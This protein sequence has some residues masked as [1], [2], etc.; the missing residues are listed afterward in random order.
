MHPWIRQLGKV[1]LACAI[2]A[3]TVVAVSG[4]GS[5]APP[6]PTKVAYTDLGLKK[7]LPPYL[8]DTILERT[9][10]ANTGPLAVS[11]YGLV[12]NLR[13]SGDTRAPT[14]V[15]DWMI[16]EMYRHGMGSLRI[17]GYRDMTPERVLADK[18]AAIVTVGAFIPPGA[19]KGQRVDAY[20]VALPQSDTASLAGGT[21]YQCELRLMGANPLNPAG[22]VNK[23]VEARGPLFINPA[24]ALQTPTVTDGVARSGAR[25]ATVLG[26]GYITADR[27]VQLRL[28]TP[29]WNISRAVE[30]V[31]NQRFQQVADKPRQDGRGMCA[32]EAQDE[33]YL[34]LYVPMSYKGNWEHF[35]GVVTHLYINLNPAVAVIKAQEL[36]QE[37]TQPGALLEDISYALEAIGPAAVPYITPL[38]AH[39]SPDVRFAMARAGTYLGDLASEDAL[40]QIAKTTG[41]PFRLNAIVCLGE[42]PNNVEINRALATCLDSEESLIRINAYK[43]LAAGGDMHVISRPVNETFIL[44][45]VDSK[46]PPLIYA[47]RIGEPRLAVFGNRTSLNQ[48]VTFTAFDTQL[49]IA[50]N[51]ERPHLLSIYYRGEELQEPIKTLSRPNVAELA[52]R[53][54]GSGDEKLRFSY[55][56]IV[57]M[58]QSMS[59]SGKVSSAFVLQDVPMVDENLL[60][61]PDATGGGGGG[62]PVGEPEAPGHRAE[63]GN[64]TT[65]PQAVGVNAGRPTGNGAPVG[66]PN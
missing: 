7:S 39:P 46:G 10:L 5:Q 42:V 9:D 3:G 11:S 65:P 58:L 59:D 43:V 4:C 8:K 2:A 47:N 15:R 54:G 51:P 66:R 56:D 49:T 27:P 34:N 17:P 16:K 41:H 26:G 53:L 29:Q 50:T 25:T 20:C 24:Y 36:A 64:T 40:I 21:L 63:A 6:K 38:L 35:M 61:T 32:A 22:S 45:I 57:G 37:A 52:A 13:Y 23:F 55:G 30:Q 19:R 62:R 33:G 12:M 44:D 14:A 1:T 31:I 18:R 28:R 48:P 60:D